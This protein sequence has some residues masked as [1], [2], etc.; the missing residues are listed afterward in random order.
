MDGSGWTTDFDGVARV[1]RRETQDTCCIVDVADVSYGDRLD[2]VLARL[3]CCTIL[4]GNGVV[5]YRGHC[6]IDVG[7]RNMR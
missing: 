1:G 5:D 7:P 4:V 6:S 2:L 3:G